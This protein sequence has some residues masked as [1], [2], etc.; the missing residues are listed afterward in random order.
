MIC[1]VAVNEGDD[2]SSVTRDVGTSQGERLR[3]VLQIKLKCFTD[4]VGPGPL[5]FRSCAFE[6]CLQFRVGSKCNQADEKDL[7]WIIGASGTIMAKPVLLTVDDDS[8]V[9]R[10]IERD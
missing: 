2:G 4:D 3:S 10:A 5:L 7:Q 9:L 8:D 1:V 6:L